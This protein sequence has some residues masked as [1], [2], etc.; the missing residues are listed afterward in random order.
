MKA[1]APL[2]RNMNCC[3]DDKIPP[4]RLEFPEPHD[5]FGNADINSGTREA[6]AAFAAPASLRSIVPSGS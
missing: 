5:S 3:S 2:D 6:G 4:S 1:L